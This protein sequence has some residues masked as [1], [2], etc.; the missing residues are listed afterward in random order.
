M[1][2]DTFITPIPITPNIIKS[3]E[4]TQPTY[5]K[6]IFTK[7]VNIR[8]SKDEIIELQSALNIIL[9]KKLPILLA[10]DGV[11]GKKTLQG[12]K[13]FQKEYSLKVDGS[14][15]PKTRKVINSIAWQ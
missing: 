4:I 13:L 11:F 12:I 6:I 7:F 14:F 8:S 9:N 3:P 2:T 5:T 15:G 1:R 10:V